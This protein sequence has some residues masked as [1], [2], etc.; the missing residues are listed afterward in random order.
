MLLHVQRHIGCLEKSLPKN[1]CS[2]QNCYHRKWQDTIKTLPSMIAWYN[3]INHFCRHW[4]HIKYLRFTYLKVCYYI[5]VIWKK[6]RTKN[7]VSFYIS[8]F[9]VIHMQFWRPVSFSNTWTFKWYNKIV[10]AYLI[11]LFVFNCQWIFAL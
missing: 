5:L 4:K 2:R 8:T 6:T 7:N 9:H 1:D 11:L 3:L 10:N